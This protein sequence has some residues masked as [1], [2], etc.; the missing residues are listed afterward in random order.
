MSERR[1]P[2]DR[3]S[4]QSRSRAGVIMEVIDPTRYVVSHEGLG[5]PQVAF[6]S[7][8]GTLAI[9]QRVRT[10]YEPELYHWQIDAQGIEVTG[11]CSL[12]PILPTSDAVAGFSSLTFHPA[13]WVLTGALQ[14]WEWTDGK[15]GALAD[16]VSVAN[17]GPGRIGISPDGEW[18]AYTRNVSPFLEVRS[19]NPATGEIGAS[20]ISNPST[21]P[22][23]RCWHPRFTSTHLLAGH[24]GTGEPVIAYEC[25]AG[26]FGAKVSAPSDVS[27]LT[28]NIL[29]FAFNGNAGVVYDAGEVVAAW[30]WTGT[31][32]G[33][34]YTNLTLGTNH[35]PSI[36]E[37]NPAGNVL[38][39]G[40]DDFVGSVQ[41]YACTWSNTTGFG[42]LQTA[43][44]GTASQATSGY[45]IDWSPNGKYLA[46]GH[47]PIDIDTFVAVYTMNGSTFADA[48]LF[49]GENF[50]FSTAVAW[51]DDETLL[52][53]TE[54]AI[55]EFTFSPGAPPKSTAPISAANVTYTPS[56]LGDWATPAP[57]TVQQALDR[58]AAGGSPP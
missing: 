21:L 39:F 12:D 15:I 14:S 52:I 22:S 43:P 7:G 58:L 35:L 2:T 53:D 5:Q 17:M 30:E 42:T 27:G 10:S 25:A 57:T 56:T 48:C 41:A 37:F 55:E 26:S 50:E 16:S 34:R 6:Y 11:E 31:A 1:M 9:G 3:P 20:P 19:F 32:W 28:T 36:P 51:A 24:R 49:D 23:G 44:V 4:R 18:I 13:G 40:N 46:V 8:A 45:T 29:G 54:N 33:T 47:Q 38:G